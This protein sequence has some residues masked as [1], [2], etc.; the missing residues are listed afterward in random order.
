MC[1]D[2]Y[3]LCICIPKPNIHIRAQ[4]NNFCA[5]RRLLSSNTSCYYH[6]PPIHIAYVRSIEECI[7]K[8]LD[9][10]SAWNYAIIKPANTLATRRH[11]RVLME[12]D[13]KSSVD[14]YIMN[15]GRQLDVQ[16]IKV[17][18]PWPTSMARSWE[19][20]WLGC[21]G[22]LEVAWTSP[23]RPIPLSSFVKTWRL[24]MPER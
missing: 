8:P 4:M 17:T 18:P 21:L 23:M 1:I 2:I 7:P 24:K 9:T 12:V 14:R 19:N 16:S 20:R 11:Q 13:I 5:W 15:S 3:T 22:C 6:P 10:R